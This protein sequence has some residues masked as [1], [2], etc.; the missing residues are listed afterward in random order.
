MYLI[1]WLK[2]DNTLGYTVEEFYFCTGIVLVKVL[3]SFSLTGY[4]YSSVRERA[5][6]W[7]NFKISRGGQHG[8]LFWS[9][10]RCKLYFSFNFENYL[11]NLNDFRNQSFSLQCTYAINPTFKRSTST[12]NHAWCWKS[13]RNFVNH[14]PPATEVSYFY[15]KAA[16]W[17]RLKIS[18][19]NATFYFDCHVKYPFLRL[20]KFSITY[21]LCLN[22]IFLI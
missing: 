16:L 8:A 6:I 4:L 7:L 15:L 21:T 20:Y 1:R 3:L 2:Q 12:I 17:R 10:I 14:P 18:A 19:R 5:L 13:S 9:K 11:F 22:G